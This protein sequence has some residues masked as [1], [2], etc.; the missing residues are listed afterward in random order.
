MKLE[1]Q[2]CSL[3]L[4][5]K[6][7]ELDVRQDSQ[8]FWTD[9]GTKHHRYQ[10]TFK[11]TAVDIDNM[12]VEGLSAFTVS[13]LGETLPSFAFSH[14]K[15]NGGGYFC[16]ADGKNFWSEAKSEANARAMM[17]IYLLENGLIGGRVNPLENAINKEVVRPPEIV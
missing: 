4:A 9:D 12:I 15:E 8:L 11:N 17:L 13:E 14:K 1:D 2:V 16:S 6:L 10:L 7:K 3:E 5:K